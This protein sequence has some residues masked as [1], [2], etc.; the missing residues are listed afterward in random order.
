MRRILSAAMVLA[1][2]AGV[3]FAVEGMDWAYPVTPKRKGPPDKEKMLDGAGQQ[4]A[5]HGGADRRQFQS[6]GLVPGRASADA[7]GGLHRPAAGR[8]RLRAVPSADRRRSS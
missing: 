4:E 7:G 2:A 1:C 8:P 6:A 3:A 5:I